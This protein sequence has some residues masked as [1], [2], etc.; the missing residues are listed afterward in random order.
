MRDFSVFNWISS[1]TTIC[2]RH[3]KKYDSD[4]DESGIFDDASEEDGEASSEEDEEDAEA[5]TWKADLMG[6]SE[7]RRV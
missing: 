4:S 5:R 1:L 6:D 7:D 3:R 2:G